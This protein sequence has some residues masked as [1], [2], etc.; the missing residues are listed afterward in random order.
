MH[1]LLICTQ[2]PQSV[3]GLNV[4]GRAGGVRASE[5]EKPKGTWRVVSFCPNIGK[6]DLTYSTLSFPYLFFV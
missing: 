1:S 5:N 2:W 3:L 6:K 4:V